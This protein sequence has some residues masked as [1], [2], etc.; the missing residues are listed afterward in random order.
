[1]GLYF[2]LKIHLHIYHYLL[3]FHKYFSPS[4]ASA[5]VAY[6]W[7]LFCRKVCVERVFPHVFTAMF[8]FLLWNSVWDCQREGEIL[9]QWG[10]DTGQWGSYLQKRWEI[11]VKCRDRWECLL[12]SLLNAIWI[13]IFI[14]SLVWVLP[15]S[16]RQQPWKQVHFSS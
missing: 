13:I 8:V 9:R 7:A 1:M 5:W 6:S 16:S 15:L 11:W 3:Y 10:R 2:I 4:K 12:P 14:K